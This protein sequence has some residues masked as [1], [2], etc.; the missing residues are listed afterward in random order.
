MECPFADI[1]RLPQRVEASG[2]P[3]HAH[4]VPAEMKVVDAVHL[5]VTGWHGEHKT[6]EQQAAVLADIGGGDRI[7]EFLTRFY[8]HAF[9]DNHIKDFFY[10]DDGTAAHAKR[11]GDWIIQKMGGEGT[12]WTDS[13]R[14]GLRQKTHQDAWRNEKRDPSVRGRRFK[15]D[16]CRIWMRLNFWAARECGLFEHEPFWTWY[17]EFIEHFMAFYEYKAP[18]YCREDAAWSADPSNLA[19]YAADGNLMKDVIGKW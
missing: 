4:V 13:G 10:Q 15:L 18:R 12:P 16:D 2:C 17:V 11:L 1:S 6:S 8:A 9:V 19:Q 5:N 14:W 3:F 7:R